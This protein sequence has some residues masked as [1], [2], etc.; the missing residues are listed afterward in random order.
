MKYTQHVFECKNEKNSKDFYE[1]LMTKKSL[2]KKDKIYFCA[3]HR[4]IDGERIFGYF[5]T[6]EIL[7]LKHF[8]YDQETFDDIFIKSSV[9]PNSFEWGYDPEYNL[10]CPACRGIAQE[11]DGYLWCEECGSINKCL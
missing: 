4:N 2:D 1:K 9:D 8:V 5:R 3:T 6:K 10:E 7:F 11:Q